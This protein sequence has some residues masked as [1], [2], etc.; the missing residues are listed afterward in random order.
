MT[1]RPRRLVHVRH[2]A[3]A[4]DPAILQHRQYDYF[5][6][7]V[8][9]RCALLSNDFAWRMLGCT[10]FFGVGGCSNSTQ[11]T[12]SGTEVRESLLV[13]LSAS[14]LKEHLLKNGLDGAVGDRRDVPPPQVIA[15]ASLT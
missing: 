4:I 9:R 14:Q 11:R 6:S 12:G 3:R 5:F 10:N 15:G 2:T 13:P 8:C 1:V 7:N